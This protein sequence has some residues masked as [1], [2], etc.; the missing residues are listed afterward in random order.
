MR[1]TV[2]IYNSNEVVEGALCSFGEETQ[3]QNFNI[4][5]VN[6]EIIQTEKYLSFL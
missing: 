6:K 3:T 5:N 1:L 2:F 4:Y